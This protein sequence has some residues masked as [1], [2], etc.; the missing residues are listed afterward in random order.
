M[1]GRIEAENKAWSLT[2]VTKNR[3]Q[4]KGEVRLEDRAQWVTAVSGR[5]LDARVRQMQQ[6]LRRHMTQNGNLLMKP[7]IFDFFMTNLDILL[8]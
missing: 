1:G 2:T 3:N 8:A 4:Q 6:I 7:N 5:V